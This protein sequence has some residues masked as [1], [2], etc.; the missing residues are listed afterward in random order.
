MKTMVIAHFKGAASQR[1]PTLWGSLKEIEKVI[2]G[3]SKAKRELNTWNWWIEGEGVSVCAHTH[4]R[5]LKEMGELHSELITCQHCSVWEVAPG[6]S[7]NTRGRNST[8]LSTEIHIIHLRC[9]RKAKQAGERAAEPPELE[10]P[11]CGCLSSWG[12]K[13]SWKIYSF[14]RQE[15]DTSCVKTQ[16]K[17][18]QYLN[19]IRWFIWHVFTSP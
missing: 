9:F 10:S 8:A 13:G 17:E 18:I 4:R 3:M 1:I 2:E 12:G 16:Q 19:I 14:W 15:S 7:C 6:E 11:G 5:E